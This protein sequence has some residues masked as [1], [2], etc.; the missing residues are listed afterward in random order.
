MKKIK[1]V[2]ASLVGYLSLA[3][4]LAFA[5]GG[6]I[7][8]SGGLTGFLNTLESLMGRV[9]PLLIGLAVI[10]FLFGVL[11]FVFNAGSEDKRKSGRDLIIYGLIGIVVMVSVWGLVYFIQNSLGLNVAT[12]IQQGPGIPNF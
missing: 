4:V 2:I 10:V 6:N 11:R 12:P 1:V 3:P 9:V 7:Q 5:Q 8:T